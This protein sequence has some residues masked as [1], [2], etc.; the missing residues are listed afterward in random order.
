MTVLL[1]DTSEQEIEV[2]VSG[3]GEANRMFIVNGIARMSHAAV[4][5]SGAGG[6]VT[7]KE[8]FTVLVGPVLTNAQFLRAVATAAPNGVNG[9]F[10]RADGWEAWLVN[11]VDADFDDETGRTRLRVEAEVQAW[12]RQVVMIAVSYQA[13][14]LAAL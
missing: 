4:N 6:I 10:V 14:I 3:P 7:A 11:E 12:G 1:T 13:T 2:W 9:Q 5:V 8:T